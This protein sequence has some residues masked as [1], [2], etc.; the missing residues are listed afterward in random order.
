M[1]IGIESSSKPVY[2]R[3]AWRAAQQH[4]LMADEAGL[5]AIERLLATPCPTGAGSMHIHILGRGN[6]IGSLSNAPETALE[7]HPDEAGF[8]ATLSACM[9]A[10]A[11][12]SRLYV[13]GSEAFLSLVRRLA[14]DRG[15]GDDIMLAE[16][17]GAGARRAQ[18]VHCKTVYDD[19]AHRA[20]DCP[21][22]KVTLVVRDHY[23]RR[24]GA[25][26]AVVLHPSDPNMSALRQE[27]L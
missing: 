18:C 27:A 7:R 19:I 10:L 12:A 13:A 1:T 9:D 26:Q 6:R 11:A 21:R 4:V 25:Y 17:A 5:I 16:L 24:I 22:C 3:L 20:F 8:S 14:R 2:G 23:S 15:L